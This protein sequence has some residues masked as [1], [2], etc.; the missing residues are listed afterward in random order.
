[1]PRTL[2]IPLL[3][4]ATHAAITT[5]ACIL[6]TPKLTSNAATP[7]TDAHVI[8]Y[9]LEPSDAAPDHRFGPIRITVLIGLNPLPTALPPV[10]LNTALSAAPLDATV[11]P[12]LPLPSPTAHMQIIS[13]G[14]PFPAHAC[15]FVGDPN[16]TDRLIGAI[17][18]PKGSG[19]TALP[20]RPLWPGLLANLAI[21]AAAWL[22]FFL[23]IDAAR[24]HIRS[25]RRR[26]NT[27]P[28]CR[29]PLTPD[30]NT[31]PECGTP[32]PDAM[33]SMQTSPPSIG[34]PNHPGGTA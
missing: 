9:R 19:L 17:H 3:A 25:R 8:A 32:N 30:I 1:M 23:T 22:A 27:C 21:F 7:L 20:Y 4:L 31:C 13:V 2:T 11:R 24:A 33:G 28:H 6:I 18:L 29:Y 15:V 16:G 10:T 5:A 14:W 34:N 26:N 12:N